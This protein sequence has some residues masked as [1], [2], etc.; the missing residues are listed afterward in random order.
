VTDLLLRIEMVRDTVWSGVRRGQRLAVYNGVKS[1][2]LFDTTRSQLWRP[3]DPPNRT[4]LPGIS[5]FGA[6]SSIENVDGSGRVSYPVG[7]SGY[8]LLY[9]GGSAF[10]T[11]PDAYFQ[12]ATYGF[13]GI[14]WNNDSIG[15]IVLP[16]PNEPGPGGGINKPKGVVQIVSGSRSFRSFGVDAVREPSTPA[17]P[18][19]SLY[20]QPARSEL[21]IALPEGNPARMGRIVV[22]DVIGRVLLS[23]EP[24]GSTI[25]MSVEDLPSGIYHVRAGASGGSMSQSFI[26]VQ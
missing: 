19:I 18:F 16:R 8:V 10:D 17:A 11:I 5:W 14:D 24:R 23:A 15:D 9:M 3:P 13:G 7:T 25:H 2:S 20:P 26:H 12:G 1:R 6:V 21:T 22:T 4:C